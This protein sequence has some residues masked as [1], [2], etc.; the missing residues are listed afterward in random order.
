MRVA[1]IVCPVLGALCAYT[2]Y[3]LESTVLQP[4]RL[5][6]LPFAFFSVLSEL[7]S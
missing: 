4:P 2:V 3:L 7:I 6:C 5:A 1:S